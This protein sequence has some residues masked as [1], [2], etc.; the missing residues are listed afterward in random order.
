MQYL[1]RYIATLLEQH[2][3]R[4]TS[5]ESASS[6]AQFSFYFKLLTILFYVPYD[7]IV[8]SGSFPRLSPNQLSSVGFVADRSVNGCL[9]RYEDLAAEFGDDYLAAINHYVTIGFPDE[10][11]VGYIEGGTM[12]SRV[13]KQP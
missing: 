10:Q 2:D 7:G 1:E 12:M 8:R 9:F 6:L 13:L 4:R 5:H 11:R 3:S